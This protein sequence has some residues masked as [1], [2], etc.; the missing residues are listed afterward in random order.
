[1]PILDIAQGG[2]RAKRS[3]LDQALC[4]H[5]IMGDFAKHGQE[6]PVVVF[7]DIKA[8]YDSTDRTIIWETLRH[9]VSEPLLRL[10][11]NM[12]DDIIVN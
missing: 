10:L 7:L 3:T 1:M 8:A 4:L 5:E 6:P 11:R 9:Y 2:F 12:F